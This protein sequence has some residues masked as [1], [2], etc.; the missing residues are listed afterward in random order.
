MGMFE[1][2]VRK[3]FGSLCLTLLIFS[4]TVSQMLVRHLE[5]IFFPFSLCSPA[6][7]PNHTS[8]GVKLGQLRQ[9]HQ[10]SDTPPQ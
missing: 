5:F 10:I 6:F 7:L 8:Y 3:I 9:L 4:Q 2:D 1:D